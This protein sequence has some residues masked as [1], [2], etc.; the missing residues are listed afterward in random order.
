M[1]NGTRNFVPGCVGKPGCADES[2]H[3]GDDSRSA[4]TG[5]ANGRTGRNR[6]PS[7]KGRKASAAGR[8]GHVVEWRRQFSELGRAAYAQGRSLEGLQS[9]YRVAGRSGWR[10]VSDLMRSISLSPELLC[11]GA[12]AIFATIDDM[13]TLSAEGYADARTDGTDARERHRSRQLQ[14]MLSEPP[15]PTSRWRRSPPPPAGWCPTRWW[16]SHW[17]PAPG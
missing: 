8:D 1:T 7:R 2:R 14:L 10:Y 12:E 3:P 15:A 9:A 13:T 17:R 16:S 6:C 11:V 4:P 5:C